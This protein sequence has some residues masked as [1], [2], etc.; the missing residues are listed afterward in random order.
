MLH[1]CLGRERLGVLRSESGTARGTVSCCPTPASPLPGAITAGD[2]WVESD[3]CRGYGQLGRSPVLKE[4]NDKPFPV[5][6]LADY[7]VTQARGT[8]RV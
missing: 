1:V 7:E 3:M 6:G 5:L 4:E 8:Q 2:L